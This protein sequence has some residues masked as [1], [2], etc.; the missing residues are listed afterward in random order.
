MRYLKT[1]EAATLLNV[2]PST[3]RVWERRFGFP[4]PQRSPGGHR[5][6]THGEVVALHEALRG[7]L[8]ISTAVVRA[9]ANLAADASSLV[10][11]LLAYD[12]D[13][14][15]RAIETT[16]ALRSVERSV[17][18]VLLPSLEQIVGRY[19][20]DSAA[21]AFSARWAAEWLARARRLAPA[22]ASRISIVLGHASRDELDLEAYYIGALELFCERAGVMVLTLPARVLHGVGAAVEVR[23]PDLVV[24]AGRQ[25]DDATIARWVSVLGRSLG[26]VPLAIYRPRL[27]LVCG[28][29]LPPGPSEAQLRIVE[30]AD[31]ADPAGLSQ[32]ARAG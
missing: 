11:A 13:G 14:A 26:S 7:G 25:L 32:L 22:P 21:W 3:L 6:Y 5:W 10:R 4:L 19:G 2:A 1:T 12:R 24:L 16:L 18:D 28:T 23:R 20:S 29:V 27:N 30:I 17:V 9:Q 8:S 31:D 15:D